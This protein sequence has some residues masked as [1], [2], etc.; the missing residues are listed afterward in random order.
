MRMVLVFYTDTNTDIGLLF[1]IHY[2][3][4]HTDTY[5][6]YLVSVVVLSGI[7]QLL[8]SYLNQAKTQSI[9]IRYAT[10]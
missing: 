9:D 2:N 6:G 5:T 1:H 10:E 3:G 8:L 4:G 7:G